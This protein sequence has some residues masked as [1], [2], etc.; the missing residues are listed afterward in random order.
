MRD[1]VTVSATHTP[2]GK[3]YRVALNDTQTQALIGH[4]VS[5]S[6]SRAGHEAAEVED[7]I[8][9]AQLQQGATSGNISRQAV[10]RSGLPLT[11][12][13][14]S[15]DRQ[16]AS[17]TIAIPGA[18]KQLLHDGIDITVGGGVERVSLVQTD[19]M[20]LSRAADSWIKD[21]KPALYVSM[22]ET[23]KTVASH[24]SI[25]RKA[26]D[27]YALQSQQRTTA[28]QVAGKLDDKIV[29]MTAVM[30]VMARNTKEISDHEVTLTKD[31]GN[32]PC[33]AK[34]PADDA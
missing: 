3:A 6:V 21:Y 13:G 33:G 4:A 22:L 23:T 25:S 11:V 16:C 28:A 7:C 31:K 9:G 15:V 20:N 29:Q 8:I 12:A 24:F 30:K 17:G 26:Q 2:I 5:Q 10:I 27:N 34:Q 32:R 19:K 18:T 1:A 14:M